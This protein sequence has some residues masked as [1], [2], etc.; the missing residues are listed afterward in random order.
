[1]F[2][3]HNYTVYLFSTQKLSVKEIMYKMALR[4]PINVNPPENMFNKN[5]PSENN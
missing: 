3:A 4:R 5:V 2:L 1:M